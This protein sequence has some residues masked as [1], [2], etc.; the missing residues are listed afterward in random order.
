[1]RYR[2]VF[3]DSAVVFFVSLSRRRQRKLLNRALELAGDPF[4]VPDFRNND[5]DGRG[6]CHVL[7]DGFI[8]S[9]WVDHAVRSV[10]IVEIEDGE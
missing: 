1:M 7:V 10:M 4:L 5:D 2:P 9:Y 8:F 6:I 3:S